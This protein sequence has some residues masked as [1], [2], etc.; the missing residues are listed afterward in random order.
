MSWNPFNSVLFTG[1]VKLF[2]YFLVCCV[3]LYIYGSTFDL[4]SLNEWPIIHVFGVCM[5]F[6]VCVGLIESKILNT[7]EES[8]EF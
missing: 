3:A 2:A 6:I 1:S 5:V 4:L 7:K 8:K